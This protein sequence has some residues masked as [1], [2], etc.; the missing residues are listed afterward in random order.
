MITSGLY[1]S[2]IYIQTLANLKYLHRNIKYISYITLN[3]LKIKL[4]K[5]SGK[6]GIFATRTPHRPNPIGLTL[7]KLEKIEKNK[8]L[9]SGVDMVEGTPIIDIKP[10]HHLESLNI[11]TIKYPNWIK[12]GSVNVSKVSKFIWDLTIL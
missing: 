8:L 9:I 2:F 11:N 7:V 6:L 5:G 4:I 12:D 3:Y 1:T 10:Y